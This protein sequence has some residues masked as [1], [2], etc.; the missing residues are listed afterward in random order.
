MAFDTSGCS[1]VN[2]VSPRFRE[3][4]WPTISSEENMPGRRPR[5]AGMAEQE[6]YKL[7]YVMPDSSGK[8]ASGVTDTVSP[9]HANCNQL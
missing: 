1:V 3:P 5:G 6:S 8:P 4:L 9:S 2:F 7:S